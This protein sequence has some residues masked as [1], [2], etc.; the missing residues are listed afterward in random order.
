MEHLSPLLFLVV[1]LAVFVDY[2]QQAFVC[3]MERHRERKGIEPPSVAL[4][5]SEP[6]VT[7]K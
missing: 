2:C 3:L 4:G 5:A 1:V 6:L 7:P